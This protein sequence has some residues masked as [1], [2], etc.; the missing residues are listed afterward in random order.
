VAQ[1]SLDRGDCAL[2]LLG[3]LR[4]R[5]MYGYELVAEL[6]ERSLEAIDLP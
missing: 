3:L 1:P 4:E 2:L 5:E 6:R